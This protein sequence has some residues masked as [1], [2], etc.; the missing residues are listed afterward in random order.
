MDERSDQE[1]VAQLRDGERQ[2]QRQAFLDLGRYLHRAVLNYLHRR[3]NDVLRLRGLDN[4]ELEELARGFTQ[5]ALR[6]VWE[7]LPTY[8]GRGRFTSWAAVIAVRTA[9][10]ELRKAYWDEERLSPPEGDQDASDMGVTFS[11]QWADT[12]MPSP[13]ARIR[14]Q[15]ILDLIETALHEDLSP[16]QRFAFVAQFFEGHSSDDI[17]RE[18][19]TTRAAVYQLIHEARKKVK[20]RL[21]A[22]GHTPEDVLA[23]FQT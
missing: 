21:L 6:I 20:R 2:V 9:G 8:A 17:A 12:R 1:W 22:A 19:G 13:E 16:R 11:W 7:K 4:Q 18:L 14:T 5:E 23:A 3:R 15:E 10:Y